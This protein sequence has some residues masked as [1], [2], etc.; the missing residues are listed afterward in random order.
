MRT[1]YKVIFGISVVMMLVSLISLVKYGLIFGVDFKGGSVTELSFKNGRPGVDE[2]NKLLKSFT[3][4]AIQ[5]ATVTAVGG[6]DAIIKTGEISEENHQQL[7]SRIKTTFPGAG[8][9]EKKFDSIGPVVGNEL[10]NKSIKAIV[11]VLIAVSVYIAFVFRKLAGN[12][13]PW[14]LGLAAIIALIHDLLIP[15]GLFAA[16]GHFRGVEISAVFVAAALTILGFSISDTVVIFDRVRENAIKYGSKLTFPET[17]HL[18]VKETLVRSINTSLTTL[19][20]LVAVY[21]FGGESVRYFALALIVGIFLGAFSSLS[22]A[23]P[24]LMWAAHRKK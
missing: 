16:L 6:Q 19:L 1:I 20:S 10:K 5:E 8:M 2:L 23:T 18:S 13:S 4:P 17:V 21:F 15:A 14:V 9:E 7:L 3:V 24:I 11:I 12:L 22:M